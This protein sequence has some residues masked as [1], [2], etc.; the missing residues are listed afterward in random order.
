VTMLKEPHSEN[1]VGIV[2]VICVPQIYIAPV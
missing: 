1:F 2:Q